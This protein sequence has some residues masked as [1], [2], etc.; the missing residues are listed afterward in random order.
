LV[1]FGRYKEHMRLSAPDRR[2][3]CLPS[4]IS[5][6]Q[7][8]VVKPPLAAASARY[9]LV[10]LSVPTALKIAADIEIWT[11]G[12]MTAAI[13]TCQRL[14]PVH[15][16]PPGFLFCRAD[17]PPPTCS[18]AMR[19]KRIALGIAQEDAALNVA[20]LK[21]NRARYDQPPTGI[22]RSPQRK[23]YIDFCGRLRSQLKLF[24]DSTRL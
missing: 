1:H 8:N 6:S 4:E 23:F 16:L 5:A 12:W 21:Q 19:L 14:T 22:R 20:Q 17:A 24:L 15:S 7:R 11:C 3:H 13:A 18:R 9:H 10:C 2:E